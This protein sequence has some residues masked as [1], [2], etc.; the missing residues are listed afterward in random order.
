MKSKWVLRFSSLSLNQMTVEFMTDPKSPTNA[1][2]IARRISI[3]DDGTYC[4]VGSRDYENLCKLL[5]SDLPTL[6]DQRDLKIT[7]DLEHW[8]QIETNPIQAIISVNAYNAYGGQRVASIPD[9]ASGETILLSD[10]MKQLIEVE[11]GLDAL[12]DKLRA[13]K[14][15]Q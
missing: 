10:L 11:N 6:L 5:Q 15:I 2:R 8:M 9:T 1:Q 14:L 12:M 3:N 13:K 7:H 4:L